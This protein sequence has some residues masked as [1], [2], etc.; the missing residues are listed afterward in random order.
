MKTFIYNRMRVDGGRIARI[1]D[2]CCR[3]VFGKFPSEWLVSKDFAKLC[4]HQ[5][6]FLL[7]SEVNQKIW[8]SQTNLVLWRNLGS[9]DVALG[10]NKY[11]YSSQNISLPSLY[12]RVPGIG[13]AFPWHPDAR[14]AIPSSLVGTSTSETLSSH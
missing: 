1:T 10:T 3:V 13:S 14:R 8:I 11:T 5:V 9:I 7:R 2:H 4:R 6:G 12:H